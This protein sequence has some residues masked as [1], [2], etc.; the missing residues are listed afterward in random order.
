MEW[1]GFTSQEDCMPLNHFLPDSDMCQLYRME[2]FFGKWLDLLH[3]ASYRVR[4][5]LPSAVD[6]WKLALHVRPTV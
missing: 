5:L 2:S 4:L 3:Q 1:E 6:N